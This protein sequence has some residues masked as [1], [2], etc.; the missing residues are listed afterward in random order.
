[1]EG[2]SIRYGEHRGKRI[3]VQEVFEAIGA[4]NAGKIDADELKAV[5]SHA[6][7]GAGAR[8]A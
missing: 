6:C 5:E 7:P 8:V 2:G 3:T 4:L 1:V